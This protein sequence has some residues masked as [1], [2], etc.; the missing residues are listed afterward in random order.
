MC[1]M[2]HTAVW[3]FVLIV[4]VVAVVTVWNSVQFPQ[5]T[6]QRTVE[7]VQMI[8]AVFYAAASRWSTGSVVLSLVFCARASHIP[9]ETDNNGKGGGLCDEHCNCVAPCQE[10][11]CFS[12]NIPFSWEH[13]ACCLAV[14]LLLLFL[15]VTWSVQRIAPICEE[16]E[17]EKPKRAF[18]PAPFFCKSW[19]KHETWNNMT[20]SLDERRWVRLHCW[21]D[22]VSGQGPMEP[23]YSPHLRLVWLDCDWWDDDEELSPFHK[24]KRNANGESID[25]ADKKL[26]SAGAAVERKIAASK[27]INVQKYA[28]MKNSGMHPLQIQVR[29]FTLFFL[30]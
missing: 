10:N 19:M 5:T 7:S 21:S 14:Y 23:K 27:E 12:L 9:R 29:T 3:M 28:T 11:H 25:D 24:V 30:L 22:W 8:L 6:V 16:E 4:V 1:V 17:K 13:H 15:A 18:L 26:R 20:T 2:L